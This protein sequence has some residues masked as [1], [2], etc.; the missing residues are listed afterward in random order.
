MPSDA[1]RLRPVVPRSDTAYRSFIVT[2]LA[3]SVLVG[4]LLAIHIP[5][6]RLLDAGWPERTADLIHG[7]GQVQLLGFA[8]LYVMGM[9]LRLLP[10]FAGARLQLEGLIPV[11]L[12]SMA[13]SLAVQ[14]VILPWTSGDLHDVLLLMSTFGVLLASGC[15]LLVVTATA[16]VEAQHPDA[17]SL[18]F[19]FGAFGLFVASAVR[20]FAAIDT[21]EAGERSIPY[22]ANV[23]VTQL[24]LLGFLLVFIVGVGLRALPVLVGR[25]RP[26]RGAGFLPAAVAFCVF[27][28]AGAVLYL[29]YATYT[30]G[31]AMVADAALLLLGLCLLLLVWQAGVLRPRANRARPAS[32]AAMWPVRGAFFWLMFAAFL[33][34]YSE[35]RRW[36]TATSSLRTKSTPCAI[37][38]APACSPT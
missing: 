27:V 9:S 13:A 34:V 33:M 10:R 15:F 6:G 8:G 29:Q 38:W 26:E 31:I 23:A 1:L 37:H 28:H 7:H 2:S 30:Q 4:F 25:D 36:S 12:W 14:S 24:Q 17:S 21:V 35:R 22:L 5:V 18:A 3:L 16:A 32:Q 11:V 20:T 19:T